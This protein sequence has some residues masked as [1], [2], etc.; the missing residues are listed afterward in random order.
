MIRHDTDVKFQHNRTDDRIFDLHE[1]SQTAVIESVRIIA[2]EL[3]GLKN[4]RTVEPSNNR[5]AYNRT[6][7]NEL[8]VGFLYGKD[9]RFFLPANS[10]QRL[11]SVARI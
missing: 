10:T 11:S 6:G 5:T 2:I 7:Y 1:V 4:C 8:T 9:L 3:N